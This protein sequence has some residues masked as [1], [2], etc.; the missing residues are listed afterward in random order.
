MATMVEPQGGRV[1][2]ALVLAASGAGGLTEGQLAARR[3]GIGASDVAAVLGFDRYRTPL[4][5][6]LDK[7]GKA[8]P[9]A[10]N[11]F[12]EWGNRLEPVVVEAVIERFEAAGQVVVARQVGTLVDPDEPW[13]L[14]TPDRVLETRDYAAWGLE[15]KCRGAYDAKAWG[16]EG[17]D[18]IPD[19]VACQVA[20]NLHVTGF[21]RW[22]VAALIGGNSLRRYTV[23]RDDELLAG[24]LDRVRDFWTRHVLAD[25]PPPL[26]GESGAHYVLDRYRTAGDLI[27]PA[28]PDTEEALGR[29][30][31][32]RE[33]LKALEAEKLDMETAIKAAI[34]G[35][36]GIEGAAGRAVW[37]QVK[38]RT[39]IDW[40]AV[41]R[42]LAVFSGEE[43]LRQYIAEY[44]TTGQPTRQF[45]FTPSKGDA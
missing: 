21:A 35:A 43:N 37:S 4:D 30:A 3:G 18:E 23:H 12:T 36:K 40:E 29:L 6:W 42:S 22:D 7:T 1:G 19:A 38:G 26:T 16:P 5:V 8:P 33:H 34:G 14:A 25:V 27:V 11:E 39:T 45:R 10:G 13:I 9:F 44:T 24:I 31:T 28:T 17:T 2:R 20:W 41:A 15:V 32:V